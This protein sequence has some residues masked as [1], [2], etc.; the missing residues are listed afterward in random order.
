M[1]KMVEL[2]REE[3]FEI[4][5]IIIHSEVIKSH[6]GL[7]IYIMSI[8]IYNFSG[9]YMATQKR[10]FSIYFGITFY[11]FNFSKYHRIQGVI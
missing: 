7:R 3:H 6:F 11:Y 5:Y 8:R 9:K 1:F 10:M 4:E 2:F